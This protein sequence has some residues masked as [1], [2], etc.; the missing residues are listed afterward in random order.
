MTDERRDQ[1]RQNAR[2]IVEK[3]TP[4]DFDLGDYSGDQAVMGVYG[5]NEEAEDDGEGELFAKGFRMMLEEYRKWR[6]THGPDDHAL[7]TI[8]RGEW[9]DLTVE[10]TESNE[11]TKDDEGI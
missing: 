7:F 9:D 2:E 6:E 11:G 1:I 8:H 3:L 10:V 5:V 4:P